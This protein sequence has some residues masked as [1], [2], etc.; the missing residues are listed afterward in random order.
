MNPLF[1][2]TQLSIEA[3]PSVAEV[4]WQGLDKAYLRVD[5]IGLWFFRLVVLG[6]FLAYSYFVT[7]F[8][9]G[10]RWS[11]AGLWVFLLLLATLLRYLGFRIKGYAV[12]QHD[13]M[14]RRGLLFRTVTVVPF[15]RIQH[16][17]VEQ[18][19]IERQFGLSSLSVFTAGGSQSD[20]AI[21]GL[22]REDAERIRNF[23][24][25]KLASDEEE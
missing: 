11:I 15:T 9:A 18:G 23:L 4:D 20:L 16:S 7:D 2:N 24:A 6:L 25:Q 3:L 1:Q 13:L 14:Y 12:R 8:P 21:P 5:L 17:E 10:I 22:K 19:V